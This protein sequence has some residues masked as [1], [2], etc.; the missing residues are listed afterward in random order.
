MLGAAAAARAD[1]IWD[2]SASGDLSNSQAAPTALPLAAGTNS[3]LGTV[4]PGDMQDWVALTVPAG[5]QLSALVLAAYQSTDVQGFIGV[6]AGP[7]FVGSP[8][9]PGSY[10]GYAHFGTGATNGPLPPTNLVGADL[11]PIMG[12]TTLAAGSQGFTPPLPSNTYTFLIQ[13]LGA[14]TA[15]QLDYNVTPVPA[16]AGLGALLLGATGVSRRR[17]ACPPTDRATR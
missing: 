16:P 13:Q 7:V 2:E 10:L 5:F 8:F 3:I 17:R 6:Q 1:V 12:D 9:S 15:Y 4:G 11:L 14:V